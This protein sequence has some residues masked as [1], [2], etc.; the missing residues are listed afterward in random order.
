[1]LPESA[2]DFE[3]M[4]PDE[5]G[6]LSPFCIEQLADV[7]RSLQRCLGFEVIHTT[8]RTAEPLAG[9]GLPRLSDENGARTAARLGARPPNAGGHAASASA[10]QGACARAAGARRLCGARSNMDDLFDQQFAGAPSASAPAPT[11]VPALASAAGHAALRLAPGLT[12]TRKGASCVGDRH[13]RQ[14]AFHGRRCDA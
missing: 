10:A 12:E 1:M 8:C 2:V 4:Q 6:H 5:N 14:T 9:H 13:L 3:V 7:V 11:P